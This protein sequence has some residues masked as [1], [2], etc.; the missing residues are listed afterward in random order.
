MYDL[1]LIDIPYVEYSMDTE[2]QAKM[3]TYRNDCNKIIYKMTGVDAKEKENYYSMGLLC[4]SAFIKKRIPDV[5]IKYYHYYLN[6]GRLKTYLRRAKIIAFSTMTVTFNTVIRMCEEAKLMNPKAKILLGGYHATYFAKE[7]LE[8]YSFVDWVIKY[9]GEVA[10][11]NI[12]KG[13]PLSGI[14]GIAY[15]DKNGKIKNNPTEEYLF[16]EEIPTPDYSLLGENIRDFNIQI[17]T[18]RGCVGHCNFCVNKNYWK[19]PRFRNI[20]DVVQEMLFFKEVVPAGTVIHI[21]DNVFTINKKRLYEFLDALEK[22]NLLNYFA[23]ECD[24]LA[25][26]IDE[27][28]VKILDKMG[29]FKV[30]LGFEDCCEEVLGLAGKENFYVKNVEAAMLIKKFSRKICVYAYWLFGLPGSTVDSL[31]CNLQMI[32]KLIRG[33]VIDIVSPKIF[34]PYPGTDFFTDSEKY[35]IEITS[36]NWDEYERRNPPFPYK[37]NTIENTEVY[38]GLLRTFDICH[39][40]YVEKMKE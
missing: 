29:V 25:S 35:L 26:A 30:G 24:T 32:S 15:R 36:R 34:I 5:N 7:I 9:E 16:G 20:D 12:L 2:L 38:R 8:Q 33:D 1:L 28:I 21:I 3:Y 22:N 17:Q 19:Y 18:A 4:M 31:E 40:N 14:T 27:E 11:T 37:C 10:I 13:I 6:D 23:F 39:N